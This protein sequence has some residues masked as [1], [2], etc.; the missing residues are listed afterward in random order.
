MFLISDADFY[1][2]YKDMPCLAAGHELE[3]SRRWLERVLQEEDYVLDL[4]RAVNALELWKAEVGI[5]VGKMATL[6]QFAGKGWQ[7]G[8][9][10]EI[11]HTIPCF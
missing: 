3:S 5:I 9:M 6:P 10:V 2:T 11:D 1:E 7:A 4:G 8:F